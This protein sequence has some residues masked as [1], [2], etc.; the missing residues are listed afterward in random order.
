MQRDPRQRWTWL[1]LALSVLLHAVL[2]LIAVTRPTPPAPA[3]QETR[4]LVWIDVEPEKPD[5]PPNVA[6]PKPAPKPKPTPTPKLTRKPDEAPV[7]PSQRLTDETPRKEVSSAPTVAPHAGPPNRPPSNHLLPGINVLN[8]V[9][10]PSHGHTITNDGTVPDP[11]AVRAEE[12]ANVAIIVDGWAKDELATARVE[13]G[14][15]DPY[16]V[17]LRRNIATQ[18]AKSPDFTELGAAGI[19]KQ[20]VSSWQAGAERYA[21]TGNPFEAP[22]MR[23]A[24]TEMPSNL[25]R[26]VDRGS[27]QAREL[28]TTLQA[29]ARLRD[30]G[31]GKMG[32]EL[33]AEVELRQ[34]G[35][36]AVEHL[37]LIRA[38]GVAQF[39]RWVLDRAST[40]VSLLDPLDGGMG[41][42][43][44]S[45]WAFRG[46]VAYNRAMRDVN[47]KEDWWYLAVAGAT[48]MMTGKFDEVTGDVQYV[49]LRHP[50]YECTVRL[51]RAYR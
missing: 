7:A 3:K 19:G 43:L 28:A 50:H 38:S 10:E 25:Q 24:P 46:R 2:L 42:Q 23:N 12:E 6:P 11:R 36:G 33:Y 17:D 1:A 49:D 39:D 26:E 35:A 18:V 15:V 32:A 27:V 14:L 9:M 5:L 16:F 21:K 37:T 31:D 45:V 47:L 48:S 22:V 29:G 51:L 8:P 13:S 34:N 44:R 20:V 4:P 30:F 41:S 40:A